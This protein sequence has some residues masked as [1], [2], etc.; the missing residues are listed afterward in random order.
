MQRGLV[1][2]RLRRLR[3]R[4]LHPDQGRVRCEQV[5]HESRTNPSRIVNYKVLVYKDFTRFFVL[6]KRRQS[7]KIWQIAAAH[8]N[9]NPATRSLNSN[10]GQI[11]S[12]TQGP[13]EPTSPTPKIHIHKV[14]DTLSK[15][16]VGGHILDKQESR[17]T[18]KT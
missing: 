3:R 4:R 7:I 8:T 15:G 2:R 6:H 18:H 1:L 14:A 17:R 9:L 5:E 11:N 16:Q 13:T 10:L 12:S